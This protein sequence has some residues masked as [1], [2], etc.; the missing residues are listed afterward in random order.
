MKSL[1]LVGLFFV[2]GCSVKYR[3]SYAVG[4]C[5]ATKGVAYKVIGVGKYSV[6]LIDQHGEESAATFNSLEFSDAQHMDCFD[7]NFPGAGK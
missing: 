4:D 5:L 7:F 2:M 1:F 6:H 3:P